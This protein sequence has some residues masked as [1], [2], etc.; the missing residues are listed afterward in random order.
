MTRDSNAAL[1]VTPCFAFSRHVGRDVHIAT[2]IGNPAPG[3]NALS[4]GRGTESQKRLALKWYEDKAVVTP[5]V[6]V[7]EIP[8]VTAPCPPMAFTSHEQTVETCRGHGS[9]YSGQAA[10]PFL[11]TWNCDHFFPALSL[12]MNGDY[13]FTYLDMNLPVLNLLMELGERNQASMRTEKRD[14]KKQE[15][16]QNKNQY[17]A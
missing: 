3:T 2:Y 13:I 7:C 4:Y 1:A 9:S 12:P 17:G 5:Y 11:E 14:I 8:K 16:P 10:I 6:E 15:K